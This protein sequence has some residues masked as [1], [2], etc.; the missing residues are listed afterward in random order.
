MTEPLGLLLVTME[1]SA[2]ADEE[3][4]DWYD[5][6]HVPERAAI[7]NFL[8]ARRFV[9]LQGWPR[10]LALY[11]L[12]YPRVLKEPDYLAISGERF[13]PWSKRILARVRGLFRAECVQLHPGRATFGAAGEPARIVLMRLRGMDRSREGDMLSGLRKVY[14]PRGDVLQLRVWRSEFDSEPCYVAAAEGHAT[15]GLDNI[16]LS[17]LGDAKRHVDLLNVYAPYW[18]RGALH[19]VFA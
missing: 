4:Q 2:A 18:R 11:D 15:L 6:E 13:S 17:P 1:P 12:A 8:T 9:C 10:Y 5:T 3:F 14:E 19:G 16:D 7:K